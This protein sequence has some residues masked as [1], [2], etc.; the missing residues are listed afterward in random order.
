MGEHSQY[1]S[2]HF[3]HSAYNLKYCLLKSI[4]SFLPCI[5]YDLLLW[6]HKLI[7][8]NFTGFFAFSETLKIMK[9]ESIIFCF[10]TNEWKMAAYIDQGFQEEIK[11]TFSQT[12]DQPCVYYH[13]THCFL[14][15]WLQRAQ[16][17]FSRKQMEKGEHGLPHFESH[18]VLY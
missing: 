7:V 3:A 2:M 10:L 5:C 18:W 12:S 1:L 11:L 16:T 14:F 8:L 6:T 4:V 13:L 15:M 17:C 9:I